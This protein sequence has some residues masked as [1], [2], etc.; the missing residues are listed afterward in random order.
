MCPIL[1]CGKRLGSKEHVLSHQYDVVCETVVDR[2]GYFVAQLR[3]FD[4]TG[5]G[6]HDMQDVVCETVLDR[7]AY[8]VAGM[9]YFETTGGGLSNPYSTLP[10]FEIAGF[11]PDQVAFTSV[12][13]GVGLPAAVSDGSSWHSQVEL[14]QGELRERQAQLRRLGWSSMG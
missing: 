11:S 9:N 2:D 12:G 3:C 7:D 10:G 8:S 13:P 5:G 14:I 1:G 6:L 4:T